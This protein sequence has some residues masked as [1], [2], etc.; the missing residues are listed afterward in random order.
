[1][2]PVLAGAFAFCVLLAAAL[3]CAPLSCTPR[4]APAPARSSAAAS[5]ASRVAVEQRAVQIQAPRVSAFMSEAAAGGHGT[6]LS[7]T[8][9]GEL[10]LD[11]AALRIL[12]GSLTLELEGWLRNAVCST[13][14]RAL[15]E[16]GVESRPVSAA[17]GLKDCMRISTPQQIAADIRKMPR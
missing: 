8:L 13:R 3:S 2:K 16:A 11:A 10:R 7:G 4:E 1:M 5:P 15:Q 12:E 9:S 14:P 17:R 6:K